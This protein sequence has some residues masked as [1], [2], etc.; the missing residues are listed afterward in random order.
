M[1]ETATIASDTIIPEIKRHFRVSA[2]PGAGKTHWLTNHIRSIIMTPGALVSAQRIACI[3]YTNTA[4]NKIIQRLENMAWRIDASTIHSFLFR[5]IVRPYLW[6]LHNSAGATLVNFAKVDGHE[7][8]RPI[9]AFVEAWLQSVSSKGQYL[10]SQLLHKN[11]HETLDY[12]R[13]IRWQYDV[14]NSKWKILL[15]RRTPPRLLPV[16]KL[17]AYKA[18]YWAAGIIDHDD[19]ILFAHRLL[20]E[21]PRL[22]NFVSASFPF[23]FIDEFQDTNPVQMKFVQ[24]LAEAGSIV[25]VVGDPEQAIF[26][27]QGATRKA[28]LGFNLSN[29]ANYLIEDNRRSTN[30]IVALLNNVR[31]DKVQQKA[32]RCQDGPPVQLLIGMPSKAIA[33]I[34]RIVGNHVVV[35]ART[36]EEVSIIRADGTVGQPD[37]WDTFRQV[38]IGSGRV[39]FWNRLISACE[40]ARAGRFGEGITTLNRSICNRNGKARKPFRY[41]ER[42]TVAQ[43]D[44][45]ALQ[46]IKIM[47]NNFNNILGRTVAEVY[48]DLAKTAE[49]SLP[50]LAMQRYGP[51]KPKTFA[52]ATQVRLLFAAVTIEEETRRFR[53]IHKAKSAEFEAVLVCFKNEESLDHIISP[54]R[55]DEEEQRITYVA[56][57]RA[58]TNLIMVAP[59]L[60]S[61]REAAL[62]D[63]QINVTRLG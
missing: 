38:D 5:N 22:R 58:R 27:F 23:I 11:G 17:D 50:G 14:V 55:Q 45:I 4:A 32:I 34:E 7:E 10:I 6:L 9:R 20:D 43:R 51:G 56:L 54:D 28:F 30:Q 33:Y 35:L 3:S 47:L 26:G 61:E 8:H 48:G 53:T 41:D 19:V 31:C 16:T 60:S 18:Q 49:E 42:L 21:N 36:N 2:G 37:P 40:L 13:A 1:T 46:L 52:D 62:L 59:S 57:S 24:W 44:G 63:L 39:E 15:P 25:G 12:L 29:H